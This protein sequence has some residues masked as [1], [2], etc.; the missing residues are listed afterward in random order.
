MSH[1]IAV[2]C[3]YND[4]DEGA[5]VGFK[6]VCSLDL[7][8]RYVQCKELYCGS[9]QCPCHT[10]YFQDRMQGERPAFPCMESRLFRDWE[11]VAGPGRESGNGSCQHLSGAR[12]GEFAVLTTTFLGALESERT[13][14]GL[15][16]IGEITEEGGETRVAAAPT[17]RIRLPLEE[18]RQLFFW[19]YCDTES[20]RPEWHG[21]LIRSLDD[22]QV[23]RIL[24]DLA[25][26]VRDEKTRGDI[27]GLIQSAFGPD[28]APQASGCLREKSARRKAAVAQ[29]RKYGLGGEGQDHRRWKEWLRQHPED[30][31]ITDAIHATAEYVFPSGDC[32]DLVFQRRGG[33]WCVVAIETLAPL[34]GAYQVIKQRAL[35][36]AEQELALNDSE[37]DAFLVAGS[38]P[39]PVE[40][41]CQ[42]YDV[43]TRKFHLR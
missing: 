38:F 32:A 6:G 14:I 36:C 43:V 1:S 29:A 11:V 22:G 35:L 23:H 31:G 25:E 42:R 37:V 34:A 10:W 2:K 41:F 3:I 9:Q 5:L 12:T 17:G 24:V 26:T 19:A 33:G 15:F 20:H 28:P 7:M 13:I 40:K 8:Q 30:I 16:Q 21:G 4:G 18:A 39:E 27:D